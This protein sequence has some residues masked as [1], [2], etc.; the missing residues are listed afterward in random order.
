[1]DIDTII[2]TVESIL[3]SASTYETEEEVSDALDRLDIANDQLEMLLN[4]SQ[5]DFE[6]ADVSESIESAKSLL[7][8]IQDSFYEEEFDEDYDEDYDDYDDEY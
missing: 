4:D 7:H 5:D 8:S 6:Y 3:E 1:M 2:S